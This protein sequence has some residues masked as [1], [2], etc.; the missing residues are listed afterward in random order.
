M[1]ES[2]LYEGTVTHRRHAPTPH[3]FAR[4]MFMVYLDLAELDTVFAGRWLWSARRPALASFRREDH[5]GDPAVPLDTAVR[6]LVEARLGWRPSGPV[7]LLTHL[8]YLGFV[9][10]PV[11]FYYCF[12]ASGHR[13]TAIVADVSNTPWGER[14]QYVVQPT[15]PDTLRFALGKQFHVSPFLPMDLDYAWHFNLP[16]ERLAVHMVNSRQGEPL[17]EATLALRRRAIDGGSLARALLRHPAMTH[18]VVAGIYVEAYRLWRKRTPFYPHPR[19]T[20]APTPLSE[21]R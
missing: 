11:S 9:F 19:Q 20:T 1:T 12:D 2:C 6:D 8:R 3:A 7:R 17:F 21:A 16:G 18:M 14:H 4:R 5:L 15:D 10:N 13:V